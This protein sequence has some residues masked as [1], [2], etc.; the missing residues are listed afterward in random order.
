[1]LISFPELLLLHETVRLE[2]PCEPPAP[3]PQ[4]LA[5]A[6]H[7]RSSSQEANTPVSEAHFQEPAH[8]LG[9][10]T[11]VVV[12][13]DAGL[14][15][16]AVASQFDSSIQTV[17]PLT[18]V[19]QPRPDVRMPLPEQSPLRLTHG[20]SLKAHSEGRHGIAQYSAERTMWFH[21]IMQCNLREK[22]HNKNESK[23]KSRYRE[24]GHNKL[25]RAKKRNNHHKNNA[26][27]TIVIV[28]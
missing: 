17:A 8:T 22:S 2:M 26:I 16:V 5:Q 19:R 18:V 28:I 12:T 4:S 23:V 11:H 24:Y 9:P 21:R 13:E 3:A 25:G 27:I 10:A 15:F 14:G 1:M 7:V 20:A 6:P